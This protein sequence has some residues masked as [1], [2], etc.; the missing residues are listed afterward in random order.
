[1]SEPNVIFLLKYAGALCTIGV[2]V[3]VA[4]KTVTEAIVKKDS[5]E[6]KK[7]CG[8]KFSDHSGKIKVLEAEADTRKERII[9][10]E[11]NYKHILDEIATIKCDIKDM[12]TAAEKNAAMTAQIYAWM[13]E[14]KQGGKR[15]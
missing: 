6:M 15:K 8:E 7:P 11:I 12:K 5:V 3:I 2:I 1:M 10:L 14:R 4:I 13:S 9:K